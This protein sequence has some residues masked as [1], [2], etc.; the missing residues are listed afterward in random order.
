M[1]FKNLLVIIIVAALFTVY[2]IYGTDFLKRRQDNAMLASQIA[3]ATLQLAQIPPTPA[4]MKQRQAAANTSMDV[5]KS[6]FPALL[7]STQ[8]VNLILKLAEGTGVKA[9]PMGTQPWATESVSEVEYPVFR[10]KIAA[11]G[12]YAQLADF[13][14]RLESGEVKTLILGNLTVTWADELSSSENEAADTLPVEATLDIAIYGRP[15]FAE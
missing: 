2:Y 15:I 3:E 7:N 12:N 4:D 14:S 8:I 10:V 6:A 5:E 9:V 1:K 11:A 13:I